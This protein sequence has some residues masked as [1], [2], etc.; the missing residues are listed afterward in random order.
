MGTQVVVITGARGGIG[1]G[2]AR[3]LAKHGAKVALLARGTVGWTPPPRTSKPPAA[4]VIPTDVADYEVEHAAARA[5]QL[6]D[7]V[8]VWINDAFTSVFPPFTQIE[9]HNYTR[10]S[11]RYGFDPRPSSTRR[12]QPT[13]DPTI[14]FQPAE[15]LLGDPPEPT[16][17]RFERL[18]PS[19]PASCRGPL[20]RACSH[21]GPR[22]AKSHEVVV[23]V[24]IDGVRPG[25]RLGA[26]LDSTAPAA[27]LATAPPR[28]WRAYAVLHLW[29]A[30]A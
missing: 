10:V 7:P 11:V 21:R 6:P 23:R 1:R 3:L 5:E 26:G 13:P 25:C 4:L 29:T 15:S 20:S 27:G 16:R 30:T 22:R 9:P 17:R 24:R 19:D 18:V 8:D 12:P 2:T 28:P 14:N